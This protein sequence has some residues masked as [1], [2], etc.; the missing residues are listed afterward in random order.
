MQNFILTQD[1]LNDIANNLILTNHAKE[2]IKERLENKT[3][4]D[5][6]KIIKH[7]FYAWNNTDNTKSIAIDNNKYF[8]IAQDFNDKSKYAL[9][10]IKEKSKNDVS[11]T[12]KLQMAFFGKRPKKR[13][14]RN[15]KHNTIP[16]TK[17]D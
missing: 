14:E 6:K 17:R 15:E 8:V 10:T 5:I 16:K 9:I 7:P 12:T 11:I 13:S 3:E 1:E 2:R 4:D